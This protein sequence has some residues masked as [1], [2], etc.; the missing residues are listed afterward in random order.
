M[1]AALFRQQLLVLPELP[2]DLHVVLLLEELL[3]L[4]QDVFQLSQLK[5]VLL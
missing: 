5:K 1:E 3:R 4:S 2:A